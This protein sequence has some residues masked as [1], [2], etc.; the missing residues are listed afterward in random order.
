M[1]TLPVILLL[2]FASSAL[3]QVPA[4]TDFAAKVAAVKVNQQLVNDL[5][6]QLVTAQTQ[7]KIVQTAG[8]QLQKDLSDAQAKVASCKAY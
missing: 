2:M 1:K 4:Q 6:S 8:A 3:A 7:L 5:Y